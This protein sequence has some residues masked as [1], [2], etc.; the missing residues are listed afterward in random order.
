MEQLL[1]TKDTHTDLLNEREKQAQEVD[2]NYEAFKKIEPS[3]LPSRKG[4]FALLHHGEIVGFFKSAWAAYL[5]GRK[6]F[7]DGAFSFQQVAAAYRSS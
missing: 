3:L 5:S 1:K 7:R 4:Q 6:R 2:R